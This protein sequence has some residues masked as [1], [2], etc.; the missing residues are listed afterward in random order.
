MVVI[1]LVYVQP[2]YSLVASSGSIHT[3]IE[4]LDTHSIFDV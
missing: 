3:V 1:M 2:V 4:S